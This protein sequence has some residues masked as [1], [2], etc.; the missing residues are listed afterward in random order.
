MRLGATLLL[1]FLAF[2][3]TATAGDKDKNK[4]TSAKDANKEINW[5]TV[6]EVQAA[7]KKEPRKVLIDFYTG[8]CG[9]CKVMDR[10]T[11]T[12]PDIVKY[13]NEKFYA[14]KFDAEQKES[15]MFLGKTY[16]FK[17]ENRANAFA[18]ELMGG[19]LSYPTTVFLMENFQN[20]AAV[21]GYLEV[22]KMETILTYLGENKH[23]S[24]KWE[25]YQK[26][27][28]PVFKLSPEEGV[29]A[30]PHGAHPSPGA[31]PVP[32]LH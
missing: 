8:W 16:E 18:A 19:R 1:A 10:K 28:K 11:Y 22:P 2:T 26:E 15:V 29:P 32:G 17:A 5:M 31:Q 24:Q 13:I 25:D 30:N 4:K 23:T 9:W 20:P 27:Y 14:V 12:N 21:P 6:D 3:F 7:M